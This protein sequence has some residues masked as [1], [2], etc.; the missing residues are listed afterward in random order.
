MPT[1]VKPGKQTKSVKNSKKHFQKSSISAEPIKTESIPRATANSCQGAVRSMG[2]AQ[3][4][5]GKGV[6]DPQLKQTINPRS[7]EGDKKTLPADDKEME[8][9]LPRCTR[10]SVTTIRDVSSVASAKMSS[11]SLSDPES[12]PPADVELL[13]SDRDPMVGQY[14]RLYP[15]LAMHSGQSSL[16]SDQ[17][18]EKSTSLQCGK[19]QKMLSQQKTQLTEQANHVREGDMPATYKDVLL[20][21][22]DR[23]DL[24]EPNTTML[25]STRSSSLELHEAKKKVEYRDQKPI[26]QQPKNCS[27][28]KMQGTEQSRS[29]LSHSKRGSQYPP[30]YNRTGSY[31]ERGA[32]RLSLQYE[33]DTR[34]RS[35]SFHSR[36]QPGLLHHRVSIWYDKVHQTYCMCTML[37]SSSRNFIV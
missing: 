29:T 25:Q 27:L 14:S 9:V 3:S 2:A 30:P 1:K 35:Q 8:S 6:V 31:E 28:Q 32:T 19:E 4:S 36:R 37:L 12:T 22:T 17:C 15:D 20:S 26:L 33:H 10:E 24:A 11:L 7:R 16:Q 23:F 18:D 21:G 5:S 13:L 34:Q